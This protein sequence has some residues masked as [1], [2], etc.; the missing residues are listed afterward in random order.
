MTAVLNPSWA[1]RIAATQP[2]GP[3]P[4]MMQSYSSVVIDRSVSAQ[5]TRGP[6]S[7]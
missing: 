4:T 3:D 5:E 2:P 6:P 1:A 7:V